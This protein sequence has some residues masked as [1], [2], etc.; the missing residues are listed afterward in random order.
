[1][2]THQSVGWRVNYIICALHIARLTGLVCVRQ[3]KVMPTLQNDG[4]SSSSFAVGLHCYT[5]KQTKTSKETAQ[6]LEP[7]Q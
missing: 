7:K 2:R 4:S 1:L 6:Q 3:P 5:D